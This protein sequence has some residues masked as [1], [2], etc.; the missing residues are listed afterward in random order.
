MHFYFKEHALFENG[1]QEAVNSKTS[2]S[3]N[4][5]RIKDSYW[6]FNKEHV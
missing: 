1:R 6:T 4:L 5:G 3:T 2:N